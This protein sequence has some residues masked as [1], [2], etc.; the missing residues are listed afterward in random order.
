MNK[1]FLYTGLMKQRGQ[2]RTNVENM[3]NYEDDIVMNNCCDTNWPICLYE[4]LYRDKV[5]QHFALRT[6]EINIVED[7]FGD[8]NNKNQIIKSSS[9]SVEN[10]LYNS[11]RD[12]YDN[13]LIER[14]NHIC[15]IDD[16]EPKFKALY[17]EKVLEFF[18]S[19]LHFSADDP[20][21]ELIENRDKIRGFID[22]CSGLVSEHNLDIN[23]FY[24]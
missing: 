1:F 19:V 18:L 4:F 20:F 8:E 7:Y 14:N 17:K 10:I 22:I 23:N 24:R 12:Q 13:L 6:K 5:K 2:G 21:D 15:Y 3:K 16:L 9:A 11:T